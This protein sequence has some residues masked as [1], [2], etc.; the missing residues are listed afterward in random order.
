MLN[1]INSKMPLYERCIPVSQMF[2]LG[3]EDE[4]KG[5]QEEEQRGEGEK[6]GKLS[7]YC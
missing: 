2:K 4:E 5:E 1:I 3:K 7:V 6:K